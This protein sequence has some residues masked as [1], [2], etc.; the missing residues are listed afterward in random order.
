M[1]VTHRELFEWLETEEKK[2]PRHRVFR[3]LYE[4]PEF[5]EDLKNAQRKEQFYNYPSLP[6]DLITV[7]K[8]REQTDPSEDESTSEDRSSP[9]VFLANHYQLFFIISSIDT[10]KE[11]LPHFKKRLS[12]Y[13]FYFSRISEPHRFSIIT[14]LPFQDDVPDDFKN[15]CKECGFGIW[16]VDPKQRKK[17]LCKAKTLRETMSADFSK[18]ADDVEGLGEAINKIVKEVNKKGTDLKDAIKGK[19]KDFCLFFEQYILD[20]TDA[21]SGVRPEDFGRRYLDRRLLYKMY[22]LKNV[23]FK[24]KIIDLVNEHLDEN[25]DDYEFVSEALDILVVRE[26]ANPIQS[27]SEDL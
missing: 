20:A 26:S 8:V 27:F 6:I 22:E 9:K 11:Q 25:L 1:K 18:S 16:L 7:T 4:C 13:S 23:S 10:L 19:S 12:F 3:E 21:T 24:D 15:F 5:Q 17:T 14:V 2:N